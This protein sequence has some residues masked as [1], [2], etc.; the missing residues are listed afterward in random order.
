[1]TEKGATPMA[2]NGGAAELRAWMPTEALMMTALV[3]ALVTAVVAVAMVLL[4]VWMN[5]HI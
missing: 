1:M 5:V 3:T 2:S 4:L